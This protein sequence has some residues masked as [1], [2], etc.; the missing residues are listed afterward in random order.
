MIGPDEDPDK[1]I[2]ELTAVAESMASMDRRC[3]RCGNS[4]TMAVSTEMDPTLNDSGIPGGNYVTVIY[5]RTCDADNA[6]A[7]RLSGFTRKDE[8]DDDDQ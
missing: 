4:D 2:E 6:Q 1:V 7:N 3:W 5:C 8:P